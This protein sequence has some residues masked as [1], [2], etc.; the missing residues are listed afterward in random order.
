MWVGLIFRRLAA[1]EWAAMNLVYP[2]RETVWSP[3]H[4]IRFYHEQID[5]ALARKSWEVN[6]V[7]H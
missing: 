7:D 4:K 5:L 2:Q 1:I 6:D 3:L